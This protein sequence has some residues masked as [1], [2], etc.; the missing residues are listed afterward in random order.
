MTSIKPLPDVEDPLTEPF[1]SAT[2][3]GRLE[4][5]ECANCGYVQWPP[6]PV[7]PNCQHTGRRWREIPAS[8]TLYTY[9]V[10]HRA[11]DPAFADDI[12]YA[13]GLVELDGVSRKMYGV[14]LDDES[15]LK[16]GARV[17]GVFEQ[18][19]DQVT[20]VRWKLDNPAEDGSEPA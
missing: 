10:Y 13:V 19:T 9:A 12:P 18:V 14:M 5:P 17:H 3:E 15:V 6:T 11:L 20:F 16:I 4:V 7:C 2:R 1:W 8:G